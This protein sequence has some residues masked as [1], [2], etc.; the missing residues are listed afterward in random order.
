MRAV[1]RP[2]M[3]AVCAVFPAVLFSLLATV[4]APAAP[5]VSGIHSADMRCDLGLPS[6]DVITLG[7]CSEPRFAACAP[8]PLPSAYTVP[9]LPTMGMP[10][11]AAAYCEALGYRYETIDDEDGQRGTCILPDGREVDAWD[12]FRG[13]VAREYSYCAREGLEVATRR[14]RVGSYTTE[15]AVCLSGEGEELGTV[16]EL[17]DLLPGTSRALWRPSDEGIPSDEGSLPGDERSSEGD[18]HTPKRMAA[19]VG[20]SPPSGVLP[21]KFDWRTL[22]GC[23]AVKSQ[24]SCGSCWAFSTVGALECNILIKDGVEVD[25]A[26]QWLVSCNHHGWSCGGGG[27]AHRYHMRTTDHCDDSGAVLEHDFPYQALNAPCDCPYPHAYWIDGWGYVQPGVTLPNVP[28]TELIKRAIVEYG[29]VS[30]GVDVGSSFSS[31]GGGVFTGGTVYDINHAVVLVGWDDN[32]GPEGVWFLR[33]SWGTMWGE[34]GYMRIAYG[35]VGVGIYANWVDYR[36]PIDLSLA[37][38]APAVVPPGTPVTLTVNL[39]QHT[40]TYMRGSA[41]MHYRFDDG[42]YSLAALEPLGDGLFEAT[43]PA[44]SCGDTPEFFFA[45]AGQRYGTIYE[46]RHADT[47]V[48]K[49]AVGQTTPVFSDNFEIDTGWAVQNDI[50]LMGGAWERGVP[51][52]GGDRSDPPTDADGSG[53]CYLTENVDGDSDVDK[54]WTRL[55]S[56]AI[57]LSG[58]TDALLEFA[59]WYRNDHGDNPNGDC[60]MVHLSDDDGVTWTKADSIGPRAPLPIGWHT[61]ALNVGDH[62]SLT[63]RVRVRFEV[64][65]LPGGSLVEAAIDDLM[66]S[67][68]TCD[69]TPGGSTGPALAL[70]P[71]VPNPFN[72]NTVI[73]F[74]LPREARVTLTVTNASGQVVRTLLDAETRAGGPQATAWDGCDDAGRRVAS[75][76]YFYR[77]DV[78]GEAVT[79]KMLLLK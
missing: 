43:L 8:A 28:D 24:G 45:A 42:K 65:D 56:P 30:V 19:S 38:A 77:L 74:E 64:N 13:K 72:P 7:C 9:D 5:I 4:A 66:V 31:Y 26:E 27:F 15:C 21:A 6:G 36:P 33:N 35:S 54:G 34:Y 57:D 32:Q 12:F 73:S 11:P 69:D 14:E 20:G 2:S 58:G 29:P 41:M 25:L 79:R 71:N 3:R 49:W 53:S 48:F 39:D 55:T 67:Y 51:V 75:G 68:L 50:E 60:L 37:D 1:S 22:D 62:V 46:P 70:H 18:R 76:A 47:D 40:D 23:T 59:Y 16:S 10:N 52:G 17:M 78:E 44:A 61:M 63:D